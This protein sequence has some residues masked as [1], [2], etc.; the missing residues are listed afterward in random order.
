MTYI[1]PS[2]NIRILKD[3]PLDT[4]YNHTIYFA[5]ASAQ[6]SYFIGKQK[7]NLTNYTYQRV[8]SNTIRV[9]LS[10]DD[11]YDCNYIMFQN[12]NFGTKWF[13]AFITEVN[14]I[15]NEV[16]E[17]RYELDVMQ[18]WFFDFELHQCFVEREHALI[19]TIGNNIAPEPVAL[20]EYVFNDYGKITSALDPLCV[21]IAVSDTGEAATTGNV[22][23]GVYS[24][25]T[26][27]A[28]NIDDTSGINTFVSQYLQSPDSIVSMYMCPVICVGQVIPEGGLV[29]TG[30]TSGWGYTSSGAALVGNEDL[31]G[32]TPVNKKMYTYPYNFFHVDNA[33][34]QALDL[35]YEFFENLTHTP[36]LKI[37]G[38]VSAP[39]KITCRPYNYKGVA[40]NVLNTEVITLDNYPQCSWNIDAYKV[41]LSQNII[42]YA[43]RILGAGA[44]LAGNV[45]Q[46][47]IGLMTGDYVGALQGAGR[48]IGSAQNVQ[49]QVSDFMS[50]AYQAS[51]SADIMR[52]SIASGNVNVSHGYQTFYGGR[53]SITAQ[54]A[55]SIDNFFTMFGYATNQ[56]KVPNTHGRPHWNYVKTGGCVIV[57]SIPADYER[58]I[59]NIHDAGITYWMN[60]D[61]VGHYDLDNT[62]GGDSD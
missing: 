61:E 30:S 42:P 31:D 40:N 56:I 59:C 33:S 17:V 46:A 36:Q 7:Y 52:G 3:V 54:Y 2:S 19:D 51:I 6:S 5:S 43:G 18:S 12:T 57:G 4:T 41:W 38:I 32:Y 15:N 39:V 20:G 58:A 27:H 14:Y 11:L 29:I 22:Y 26:Y 35:R 9:G 48:A 28:Y 55:R 34:G 53:C 50:S 62:I 49:T 1:A 37:D 23:D 45:G 13:Y 24:G 60:G 16:A 44:G 10:A 21:I 47:G 8:N 25:V